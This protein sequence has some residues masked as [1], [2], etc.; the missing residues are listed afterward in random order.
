MRRY[1][2]LEITDRILEIRLIS[3]GSFL[4]ILF[5]DPLYS[6]TVLKLNTFS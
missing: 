4:L 3:F 1:F 2:K 6:I 5:N